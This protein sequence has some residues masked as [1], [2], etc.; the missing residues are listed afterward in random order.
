MGG[1]TLGLNLALD[2]IADKNE[3]TLIEK[4]EKRCNYI[5][6]ELDTSVICGNGTDRKTLENANIENA[7]AF[8]AMTGNDE[9]NL[10]ASLMARE[11]APE[12]VIARLNET[13]H[14]NVF[15]AHSNITIIVP[16]SIEAGYLE[17]LILK[18]NITDL[19]VVDHGKADLIE[20]YVTNNKLI[21]KQVH[22]LSPT[23]DYIIIGIHKN[24]ADTITIPRSDMVVKE[25]CRIS[26]LV[27]KES[28][29]KVLKKFSN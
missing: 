16:E 27:K 10:L 13:Q 4:D 12:K 29:S 26:L 2:L 23:E 8:I 14:E 7:D 18:P 15:L 21:G 20:I 5:V 17:K 25:N 9:C 24:D 28:I 1:G 11:Y 6:K 3:V 19:F 22:E